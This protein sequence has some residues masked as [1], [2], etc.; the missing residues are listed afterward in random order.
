[1]THILDREERRIYTSWLSGLKRTAMGRWRNSSSK[2]AISL[3]RALVVSG[4][5]LLLTCT[6][7]ARKTML[8]RG[9]IHLCSL[10]CLKDR[11]F[12]FL[13]LL[14]SN[15]ML[16]RWIGHTSFV[17]LWSS[18]IDSVHTAGQH[19]LPPHHSAYSNPSLWTCCGP[20]N[21]LS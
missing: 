1:M 5:H 14:S 15:T 13:L 21:S 3:H 4:T 16:K 20:I 19:L 6:N 10:K 9:I 8:L 18:A 2:H 12:G 17:C 11:Q 7:L